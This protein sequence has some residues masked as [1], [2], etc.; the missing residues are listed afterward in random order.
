[1]TTILI[2]EDDVVVR[3]ILGVVL[4]RQGWAVRAVGGGHDCL[5]VL[6]EV[7][8]NLVVLDVEMP[9]L[10]GWETLAAIRRDS[11]VPVI[12]LTA[13]AGDEHRQRGEQR[14]ADGFITKPFI[15]RDLIDLVTRL[16]DERAPRDPGTA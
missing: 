7:P 15:N 9:S 14:G 4:E 3:E 11:D 8:I 10:D 16:L 1:M 6:A 13:L 5:A 12:L 2:A